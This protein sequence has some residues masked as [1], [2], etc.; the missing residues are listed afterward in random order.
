MPTLLTIG[1]FHQSINVPNKPGKTGLNDIPDHSVRDGSV[2]VGQKIAK[3]YD[4]AGFDYLA[5]QIGRS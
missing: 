1:S 3:V 2:A 4:F 5:L